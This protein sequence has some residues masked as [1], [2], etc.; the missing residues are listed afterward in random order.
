MLGQALKCSFCKYWNIRFARTGNPKWT[1]NTSSLHPPRRPKPTQLVS[2]LKG[3]QCLPPTS[4]IYSVST[5][6]ISFTQP[7]SGPIDRTPPLAHLFSSFLNPSRWPYLWTF[8]V[9][10]SSCLLFSY[11]CDVFILKMCRKYNFFCWNF[12]TVSESTQ[13]L[14]EDIDFVRIGGLTASFLFQVTEINTS[15][16]IGRSRISF[17]LINIEQSSQNFYPTRVCAQFRRRLSAINSAIRHSGWLQDTAIFGISPFFSSP[18]FSAFF[19]LSPN[20]I[21][22]A[23]QFVCA[24]FYDFWLCISRISGAISWT[25]SWFFPVQDPVFFVD[26][27]NSTASW[28]VFFLTNNS[29]KAQTPFWGA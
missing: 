29:D 19:W 24:A 22:N 27:H 10:Y 12:S 1:I 14:N 25:I 3:F 7:V 18:R 16:R 6:L 8:I 2:F 17:G 11:S 26:S 13:H 23:S 15:L 28:Q 9:F 21:K 4:L 20:P 5:F